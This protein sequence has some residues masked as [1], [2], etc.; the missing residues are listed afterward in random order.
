MDHD[1]TGC[2]APPERPILCINNCGFFGSA[3]TMNMCSKCH[4]D[5]LMKQE[6]SKLTASSAGSILGGSSSS[7]LEQLI[8]A[9]TVNIQ[10]NVEES[11]PIAVQPSYISELGESVE[12]KPKEGPNRCNA[13][14]K[15][16][17]LTGFKCRCG[18]LFC[19][20]HRYSDKH[21]CQ[22]DYRNAA[23]EAIAKA[24]PIVRAE[25]LDKI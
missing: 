22:F 2:Q 11:K 21:D 19:A 5:M 6:Q 17:G 15:R 8:A 24:N 10:P 13:C 7:S 1:E 9:G 4:K 14:K 3:A 25:K 20:S 18:N 16:V 12:A 23:R